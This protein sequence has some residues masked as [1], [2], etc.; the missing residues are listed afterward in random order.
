MLQDTN[1]ALRV[2]LDEVEMSNTGLAAAVVA[3]GAK[4]GLHLG[5]ST[6]SVRR[7]LDGSQPH[8]P[9]PRLVAAALSGRL[10]REVTISDCGF[11][12]RTPPDEDPHD[13]LTTSGTLEGAVL[14]LSNSRDGTCAD[15]SCCWARCS[16]QQ[17][18]PNQPW[19]L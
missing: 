10:R 15:A 13:G 3:A 9:T 5:T 18:S 16:A 14:T 12:D 4:E 7:M 17:P 2:L 8:W 1:T 19:W 6:T 11:A